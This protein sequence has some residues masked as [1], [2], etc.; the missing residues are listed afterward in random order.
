MPAP[1]TAA[2]RTLETAYDEAIRDTSRI[3]TY[4]SYAIA[5]GRFGNRFQDAHLTIGGTRPIGEIR[6]AGIYPVYRGGGFMVADADSRYGLLAPALLGATVLG[7]GPLDVRQVFSARVL[8]WRG[9]V[10]VEADW[11][12]WAPLL[13]TDYGPPTPPGPQ[14]CRFAIG[15]R[16]I[17]LPLQ[18]RTTTASHS[19][20]CTSRSSA[21]TVRVCTHTRASG[22][23]ARRS[24]TTRTESTRR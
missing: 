9:R 3:T 12:R 8:T 23:K 21:I 18:W 20:S 11:F 5:L 15:D 17:E 10:A 1:F 6:E 19:R 2:A 22:R 4:A 14:S 16:T 13:F 24:S 7:C